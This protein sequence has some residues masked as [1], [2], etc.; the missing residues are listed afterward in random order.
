[1]LCTRIVHCST[2]S[3]AGKAAHLL[4]GRRLVCSLAAVPAEREAACAAHGERPA[5][6]QC[7][8]GDS[9]GLDLL[10]EGDAVAAARAG[11]PL[12]VWVAVD[13]AIQHLALQPRMAAGQA[14]EFRYGLTLPFCMYR[15]CVTCIWC[16]RNAAMTFSIQMASHQIAK[17][18][19]MA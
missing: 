13:V 7:L 19:E 5:A 3:E 4:A 6:F 14:L 15:A 1:M 18:H 2:R 10:Q 17:T 12:D 9:T 16:M 8:D 11:A